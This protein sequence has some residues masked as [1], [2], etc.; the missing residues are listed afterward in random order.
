MLNYSPISRI[1]IAH[2]DVIISN[3]KT[4][5]FSVSFFTFPIVKKCFCGFFLN[6]SVKKTLGWNSLTTWWLKEW[7][8]KEGKQSIHRIKAQKAYLNNEKKQRRLLKTF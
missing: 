5:I 6:I 1:S 4:V 2:T 8:V 3:N 7:F